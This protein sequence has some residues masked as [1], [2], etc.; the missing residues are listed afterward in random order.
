MKKLKLGVF[1]LVLTLAV[2]GITQRAATAQEDL[3][4][5]TIAG[6]VQYMEKLGGYYIRGEN[7]E[8]PFIIANPNTKVLKRVMKAGETITIKGYFPKDAVLLYI[9]E[10]NG[11]PYHGKKWVL[12]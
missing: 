7:S 6:T 5:I 4:S 11:D 8:G 3:P 12:P 1:V 10:I 9:E 2:V